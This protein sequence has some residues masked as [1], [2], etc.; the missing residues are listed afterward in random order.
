[1]IRS[2]L[3]T[4]GRSP[5][6][7]TPL[8]C[9]LPPPTVFSLTPSPG[10]KLVVGAEVR[11]ARLSGTFPPFPPHFRLRL[12]GPLISFLSGRMVESCFQW[13]RTLNR[14][15][16]SAR[17]PAVC[18]EPVLLPDDSPY[19]RLTLETP[20]PS[21]TP[22]PASFLNYQLTPDINNDGCQFP[23]PEKSLIPSFAFSIA[24]TGCQ[25]P[26][27]S[28]PLM[29]TGLPFVPAPFF[30]SS[31]LKRG[32]HRHLCPPYVLSATPSASFFG[33]ARSL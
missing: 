23:T 11:F 32:Q 21:K 17:T 6:L 5:L 13:G 9:P 24:V 15:N 18:F 20:D 31:P 10:L 14:T 4:Y 2:F 29:Q 27:L 16:F 1:V 3:S 30:A 12:R 25:A 33:L 26:K 19:T 8:C 22:T 28:Y 7:L